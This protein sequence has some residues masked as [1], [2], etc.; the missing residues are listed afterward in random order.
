MVTPPD[1]TRPRKPE[2]RPPPR[3]PLI[4]L[5]ALLCWAAIAA[6]AWKT[7]RLNA[8]PD[9]PALHKHIQGAFKTVEEVEGQPLAIR[10]A[11][12]ASARLAGLAAPETADAAASAL[13]R[14]KELAPPGTRVYVDF[15]PVPAESSPGPPPASI[16]LPPHDAETRMPFPY[17][18][19]RLL[20]AELVREGAAKVDPDALYRFR[21]ELGALQD[22]ARRHGRGLWQHTDDK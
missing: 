15:E 21:T 20:N 17:P 3:Q 16:Y 12:G 4:W 9:L 11:D 10:F 1:P 7:Y 2:R 14:L 22:D 5:L 13:E 18:E 6:W 8:P 19:S